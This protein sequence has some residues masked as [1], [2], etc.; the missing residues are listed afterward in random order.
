MSLLISKIMDTD[1]SA[2][3]DDLLPN[4][5]L[6]VLSLSQCSATALCYSAFVIFGVC[7]C[8]Y[9]FLNTLSGMIYVAGLIDVLLIFS[10][11]K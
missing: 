5:A 3:T 2:L 1:R 10:S 6:L 4:V 9:L 8:A 11:R 7:V